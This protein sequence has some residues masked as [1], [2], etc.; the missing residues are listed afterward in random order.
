MAY[1][2]HQALVAQAGLT[3]CMQQ[4]GDVLM[5]S[6]VQ[7]CSHHIGHCAQ[8]GCVPSLYMGYMKG[9]VQGKGHVQ[10]GTPAFFLN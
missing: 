2:G 6:G 7:P 10:E 5:Y 3:W 9:D 1:I 4:H 8:A